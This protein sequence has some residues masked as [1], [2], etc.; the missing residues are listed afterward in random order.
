MCSG[1]STEI[2]EKLCEQLELLAESAEQA[3][4]VPEWRKCAD[5]VRQVAQ[6]L[7]RGYYDE[8]LKSVEEKASVAE[9]AERLTT[10]SAA[11][12]SILKP[13]DPKLEDVVALMEAWCQ[14]P[15]ADYDHLADDMM[16][17]L[18]DGIDT[19]LDICLSDLAQDKPALCSTA[20]FFTLHGEGSAHSPGIR[21]PHPQELERVNTEGA[22]PP[23]VSKLGSLNSR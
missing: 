4:S 14:L 15:D 9:T 17:K 21:Y 3:K 11:M 7:Q 23:H 20:E 12:T 2:E 5:V 19:V 1:T 10:V 6:T 8:L 13:T 18:R 22:T 16:C